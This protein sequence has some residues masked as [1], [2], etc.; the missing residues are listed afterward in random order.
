MLFTQ[1]HPDSGVNSCLTFLKTAGASLLQEHMKW[2]AMAAS[3]E[4]KICLKQNCFQKGTVT[5]CNEYFS[6]TLLLAV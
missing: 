3:A 1:I 6:L 4:R 5:N 2:P